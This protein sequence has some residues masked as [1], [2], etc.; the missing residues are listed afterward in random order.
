MIHSG[1]EHGPAFNA[2][3][4]FHLQV[5]WPNFSLPADRKL[6]NTYVTHTSVLPPYA[7][8]LYTFTAPAD[9]AQC[10]TATSSRECM[11]QGKSINPNPNVE[12]SKLP[13]PMSPALAPFR[14]ER[15]H[16]SSSMCA[17]T[18]VSGQKQNAPVAFFNPKLLNCVALAVD[19]PELPEVFMESRFPSHQWDALLVLPKS[20]L[21]KRTLDEFGLQE[22]VHT[23]CCW[24]PSQAAGGMKA[25]QIKAI[26]WN[27]MGTP[28]FANVGRIPDVF[29]SRLQLRAVFTCL[30]SMW[31]LLRR[32]TSTCLEKSERICLCFT[33]AA[34]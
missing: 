25:K 5:H 29:N 9:F 32:W 1:K 20:V 16:S 8:V 3:V 27:A 12:H 18:L 21:T 23:F 33:H 15:S 24:V 28:G 19:A 22:R 13:V 17:K 4:Q 34:I 7:H 6:V 11:R 30:V 31:V 26:D 10:K 14:P 2:R